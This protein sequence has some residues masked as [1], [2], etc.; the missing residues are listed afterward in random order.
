MKVKIQPPGVKVPL[1]RKK[2]IFL[3]DRNFFSPDLIITIA[4]RLSLSKLSSI[5][6][7]FC[8]IALFHVHGMSWFLTG[9][10]SRITAFCF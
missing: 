8:K 4:K 3:A 1:T 10:I 9:V 6:Y 7:E 2:F 5:L